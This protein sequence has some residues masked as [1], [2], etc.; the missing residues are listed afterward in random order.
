MPHNFNLKRFQSLLKLQQKD[1]LIFLENKEQRKEYL[2][3]SKVLNNQIFFNNKKTYLALL[4]QYLNGNLS[5]FK[6]RLEFLQ[7]YKEDKKIFKDLTKNYQ[8]LFSFPINPKSNGFSSIIGDLFDYVIDIAPT[9]DE[10][11]TNIMT[12]ILVK[13]EDYSELTNSVETVNVST[14]DNLCFSEKL[15]ARSFEI[16]KAVG[17][18]F[19]SFLVIPY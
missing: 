5:F 7:T 11:F 10:S 13:I 1:P 2:F 3:Y 14:H 4:N 18:I 15:Y 12:K 6:F 9:Y 19:I 8:K 16:L 17:L